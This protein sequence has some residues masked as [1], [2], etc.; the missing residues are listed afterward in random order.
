[1]KKTLLALTMFSTLS[2]TSFAAEDL[3]DF[4][5]HQARRPARIGLGTGTAV[6]AGIGGLC[7]LLV[8]DETAKKASAGTFISIA[9][10]LGVLAAATD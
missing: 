3:E 2:A 7:A 1:M 10:I 5:R 6:A 9:M 8:Q 4:R